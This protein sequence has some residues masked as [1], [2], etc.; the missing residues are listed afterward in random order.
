MH[1]THK[2]TNIQKIYKILLITAN[3]LAELACTLSP[4]EGQSIL[5]GGYLGYL[6]Y[7]GGY[8]GSLPQSI[9]TQSNHLM[10]GG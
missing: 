3:V 6:G 5:L 10:Y 7:L 1:I 4:F 2:F 8:L 9:H